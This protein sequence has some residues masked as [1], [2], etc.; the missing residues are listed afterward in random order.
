MTRQKRIPRLMA[1]VL[2]LAMV[3]SAVTPALATGVTW[4]TGEVT[5]N[6]VGLYTPTDTEGQPIA[7]AEQIT[8]P[9]MSAP[10][11]PDHAFV[12]YEKEVTHVYSRQHLPYIQGY[13][14]GSV[15]PEREMVRS[16]AAMIL[17]RMFWWERDSAD[18]T[19]DQR[20]HRDTFIDVSVGNWFYEAV[21]TLYNLGVIEQYESGTFRPNDPITREEL[22]VMTAR[23]AD[24]DRSIAPQ[25]VFSD[26]EHGYW[27][28]PYI[29]AA[30]EAG[31]VVGYPDGTFRPHQPIIRAEVV[32]LINRVLDRT[33]APADVPWGVNPY[34]DL[35]STHWAFGDLIEATVLHCMIDWHGTA[36]LDGA[37]NVVTERF[38]NE[39]GEEIADPI[40]RAGATEHHPRTF[41]GYTYY[42]YVIEIVYIYR[43]AAGDPQPY[44]RKVPSV[45]SAEVGQMVLYAITIGNTETATYPWRDVVL[46]DAIPE[47][48]IFQHGSVFVGGLSAQHFYQD[49]VLTVPIGDLYPGEQVLV[50]FRVRVAESAFGQTIH[51]VAVVES[52]N[53][54]D[55]EAPDGGIEI[56]DGRAFP[57]AT[58]TADRT[59]AQVGDRVTYT[60]V[61]TN[62]YRATVD[63]RDVVLTD[64]LDSGLTFEHG[65]VQ[66]DGRTATHSYANRTL[67]VE[68]GDI[69]PD[70][71]VTVTF[72][73]VV[74]STAF[75]Q[76]IH[77]V[78]L[79]D[80]GNGGPV[81]APAED[82][83]VDRGTSW[84]QVFKSADRSAAS[85]GDTITYTVRATNV[86]VATDYWQNVVMTDV[87]PQHLEFIDGS[88]T[89]NGSTA[90]VDSNFDA[91]TRTLTVRLGDIAPSETATVTFRV[92][93]LEG[94]QGMF[95]V[96]VAYVGCDNTDPI[97]AP[98]QGVEIDA[99]DPT[100]S[101]RKTA[102]VST[103]Q[104][105]DRVTY[106]ITLSNSITATAPWRNVVIND[107]I[108]AG[109]SFVHGSVL[110]DG[111]SHV[112]GVAGQALTIRVGDIVPGQTVTVTFQVTALASGMGQTWFNVA[113][114]SSDNGPQDQVTDDGVTI[115]DEEFGTS[116]PNAPL[117]VTATKSAGTPLARPGEIVTYTITAQN[118]AD[119]T[120][121]NVT[122]TDLLDTGAVTFLSGSVQINGI[123]AN[124][125]QH[126]YRNRLLTVRLGDIV[127]GQTVVVEFRVVI[128]PDAHDT[129]I[130]NTVTL[131][132]SSVRDGVLDT[133]VRASAQVPIPREPNPPVSG[134]HMQ[135][136]QGYPDGTWRPNNNIT[137]A[138]AALV[139]YRILVRPGTGTANI[140]PDVTTGSG[141]FA[142]DAIRYF[143]SVGAMS[144]DGSGNFNPN[145]EITMRDMNRLARE[146]MG[147]SLLPDTSDFLSRILTAALIAEAQGR[148]FNPNTNG[149]PYNTFTDV[150]RSHQWYGLVTEMSTDHGY[151]YDLH[152]NEIW[153]AF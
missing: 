73:A 87:I 136:F 52:E 86:G 67:T 30:A 94:A 85:V 35:V 102:N 130:H 38:V 59:T 31:W 105:G 98:D 60:I 148:S 61:V 29:H 47:G 51:N 64:V 134:I 37:I 69:A 146:V 108:P 97:P 151:F 62:G 3:L 10:D 144:V 44:V 88:V 63:W 111:I 126:D 132:G 66:V 95:I 40:V 58:K 119:H 36:F 1:I 113:T 84:G 57:E 56:A 15:G 112:H 109:F 100:P 19:R 125:S 150:P 50:E 18:F 137:R 124:S 53:V 41:D 79:L 138:E 145:A 101:A 147:Q 93:V 46:V 5:T 117:Q 141:L 81:E 122:M 22:A 54:P 68:L 118:T 80:G 129:T 92:R 103:V 99:G 127:P 45:T 110:V 143:L 104:V 20:F 2:V 77:N 7:S 14:D 65:S 8:G 26:V 11:I 43:Y 128:K 74:N 96:N 114:I 131:I 120:W 133:M 107:V 91:N 27:S 49:G 33:L 24:L 48:M 13:P 16:E 121:Y 6:F 75:G 25:S 115:P 76:T 12:S 135:L 23:F 4:Q 28:T 17:H 32:T 34:N 152:G 9:V 123:P 153:E 82:I 21:E 71:S 42:G 139:F 89:V 55:Q 78:A 140:P 116:D 83:E 106:T 72:S 90:N 142:V 70:T 149:L 39:Y